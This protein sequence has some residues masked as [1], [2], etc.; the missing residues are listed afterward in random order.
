MGVSINWGP[1]TT[2]S[3]KNKAL[4]FGVD[5]RGPPEFLE[6]PVSFQCNLIWRPTQLPTPFRGM[7]WGISCQSYILDMGP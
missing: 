5:I 3:L 4:L 2:M 1:Y 6:T 7:F